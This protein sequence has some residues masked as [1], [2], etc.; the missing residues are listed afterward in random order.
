MYAY[1][2]L[3]VVRVAFIHPRLL[4]QRAGF[5]SRRHYQRQPPTTTTLTATTTTT[6]TVRARVQVLVHLRQIT[7][8]EAAVGVIILPT[9]A[10]AVA[11]AAEGEEYHAEV[12]A[13][14]ASALTGTVP[15]RAI[16][17]EPPTLVATRRPHH[18]IRLHPL[19]PQAR[20]HLLLPPAIL[21]IRLPPPLPQTTMQPLVAPAALIPTLLAP[22]L[23][24]TLTLI[25]SPAVRTETNLSSINRNRIEAPVPLRGDR[26]EVSQATV[27]LC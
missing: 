26:D 22:P 10:V 15:A 17:P 19:P 2:R 3:L 6:I 12:E 7:T 27:F 16:V 24:L 20:V 9:T 4:L 8:A 5:R 1:I 18:V 25:L 11:V 14:V 13:T 23:P 21:N